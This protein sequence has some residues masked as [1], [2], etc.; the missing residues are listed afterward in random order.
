METVMET[1]TDTEINP[2]DLPVSSCLQRFDFIELQIQRIDESIRREHC[3]KVVRS[4]D[5]P[6][7]PQTMS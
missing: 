4:L 1:V 2:R 5:S 7:P 3:E 6:L